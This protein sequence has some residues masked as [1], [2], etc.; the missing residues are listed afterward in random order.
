MSPTDP[1][2]Y[3]SAE[4]TPKGILQSR[5]VIAALVAEAATLAHTF[6]WSLPLNQ[7][8]ATSL[9]LSLVQ[10]IAIAAA[11]L[12]RIRA[13]RTV[14]PKQLIVSDRSPERLQR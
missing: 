3:T 11:A 7:H 9:V 14:T 13:R 1:T 2:S 12:G 5:T 6:G 4:P 8:D 10:I